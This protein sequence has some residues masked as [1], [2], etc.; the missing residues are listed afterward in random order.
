MQSRQLIQ[1]EVDEAFVK[2]ALCKFYTDEMTMQKKVKKKTCHMFLL[3]SL[4]YEL[5]KLGLPFVA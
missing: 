4:F 3:H 2:L 1:R 5:W